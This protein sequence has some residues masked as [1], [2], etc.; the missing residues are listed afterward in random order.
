[1]EPSKLY[2]GF[3]ISC[4]KKNTNSIKIINYVKNTV[5]YGHQFTSSAVFYMLTLALILQSSV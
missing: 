4:K 1:M 2:K 5:Q 3:D